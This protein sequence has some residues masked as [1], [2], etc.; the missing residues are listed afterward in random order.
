MSEPIKD[1][2]KLAN[3]VAKRLGYTKKYLDDIIDKTP[4]KSHKDYQT[5][6]KTFKLMRPFW[7]LMYKLNRIPK[8]FYIKYTK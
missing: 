3:A 7:W 6:K 5:Y 8:S 1:G 2:N 4:K